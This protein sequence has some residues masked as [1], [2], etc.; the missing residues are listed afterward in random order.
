MKY[1]ETHIEALKSVGHENA[2]KLSNGIYGGELAYRFDDEKQ[3]VFITIYKNK[4]GFRVGPIKKYY[5][6]TGLGVRG[7]DIKEV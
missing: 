7:F 5:G 2:V 4:N 3:R 6:R 1:F